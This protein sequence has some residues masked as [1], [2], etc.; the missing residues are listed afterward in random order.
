[1]TVMHQDRNKEKQRNP[2]SKATIKIFLNLNFIFIASKM[3]YYR[4]ML[5]EILVQSLML[6]KM[7]N[8]RIFTVTVSC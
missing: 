2:E 7:V 3:F 5:M 4:L 1:M 8:E 6:K